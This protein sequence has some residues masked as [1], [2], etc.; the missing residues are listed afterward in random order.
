MKAFVMKEIGSVGFTEKPVPEPGPFDAVV[1]TTTALICTSDSHT[2]Q[3][4]IG[5]RENLTLGH[6]AVGVVH[7]VGSEVRH[8]RPNDRVLAGA[9]TPD[10]GD[11]AAQNGFPSQSGG[12]LGGF[13][14]ANSKD[15][16]FAE[17]FHVNDADANLAVIP[18]GIP[19]EWAVYCSDMLSTGFM[20]AEKGNIPIGG[21]VA[22]LAQGPVGLMSTA[23]AKLR[24]AGLIIGVESVP[25]RQALARRYGAG[26]IIDFTSEDVVERVLELTGGEGVDT[27]IEA[28][29]ADVTFQTAVKITKPGGTISN[30]GY[31]GDGEFVRIPRVEWGVGMADKTI[32]TGLCPGGRLRMERLLRILESGQVDPT[33]MTT[34]EFAFDDMEQAFEVSDK[35]LDDVVKVLIRF[36]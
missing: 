24:G 11:A 7:A 2:V 17:Y 16:V 15:G 18:D 36:G 13:K 19:D 9:I 14:F 33:P 27:A 6:E 34:H 21:T 28:L 30:V 10:W 3:G 5:P 35:K 1:R 22:V 32:A 4:G 25:A 29:G 8:I 31:F 12:P 23:G 26:E 20:G